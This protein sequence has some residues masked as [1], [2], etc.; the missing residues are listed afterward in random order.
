MNQSGGALDS[1]LLICFALSFIYHLA[2][3]LHLLLLPVPVLLPPPDEVGGDAEPG[4]GEEE[5]GG[6]GDKNIFFLN[7]DI[8][9]IYQVEGDVVA[10]APLVH[11]SGQGRALSGMN[12]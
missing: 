1:S 11:G 9:N 7:I 5:G 8:N 3:L 6:Q 2:L 12:I 4:G 10:A